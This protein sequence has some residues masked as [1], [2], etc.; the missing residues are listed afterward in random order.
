MNDA[1]TIAAD[2]EFTLGV[3]GTPGNA[4]NDQGA[5]DITSGSSFTE[6]G[7]SDASWVLFR[8]E[9]QPLAFD[10]SCTVGELGSG[11]GSFYLTNSDRTAAVVVMPTGG[12]RL[13]SYQEIWSD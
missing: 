9:G 6:P 8:P 4:P 13:H 2:G 10:S 7:G 12:T 5:G 1:G 3:T 11:A